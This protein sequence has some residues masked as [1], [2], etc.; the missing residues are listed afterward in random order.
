MKILKYAVL[1]ALL[2][3]FMLLCSTAVMKIFDLLLSLS[4]E[5][6]WDIGCKVGFVSWLVLLVCT[7]ISKTKNKKQ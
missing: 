6:I 1:E 5:N 4:Y 7:V 2:L 3:L